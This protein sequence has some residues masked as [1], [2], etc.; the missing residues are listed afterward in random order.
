MIGEYNRSG[1]GNT[2]SLVYSMSFIN[3]NSILFTGITQNNVYLAINSSSVTLIYYSCLP[4]AF[5]RSLVALTPGNTLV[6][7]TGLYTE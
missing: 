4:C 1:L 6:I 7:H 2:T 3:A 5:N